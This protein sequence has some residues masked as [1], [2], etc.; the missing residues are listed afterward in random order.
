M[1]A[2][3]SKVGAAEQGKVGDAAMVQVLL[4]AHLETIAGTERSQR[5]KD[6]DEAIEKIPVILSQ[7]LASCSNAVSHVVKPDGSL[8]PVEAF[9]VLRREESKSLFR[10]IVLSSL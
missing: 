10:R 8:A 1:K 7:M 9:G 4:Q 3:T 6:V 5:I 2:R